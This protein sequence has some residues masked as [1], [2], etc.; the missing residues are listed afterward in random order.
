MFLSLTLY[1]AS[2]LQYFPKGGSLRGNSLNTTMLP[3]CGHQEHDILGKVI[4]TCAN[5]SVRKQQHRHLLQKMLTWVATLQKLQGRLGLQSKVTELM[6][7]VILMNSYFAGPTGAM[8]QTL[9]ALEKPTGQLPVCITLQSLIHHTPEPRA[10][11]GERAPHKPTQAKI[12]PNL[13]KKRFECLC[14]K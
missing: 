5:W 12:Q 7:E 6:L 10:A 13:C 1:L 11:G 9:C 3:P 14:S 4:S 8:E 2:P